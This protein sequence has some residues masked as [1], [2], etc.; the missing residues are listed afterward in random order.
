LAGISYNKFSGR[1]G[2]HQRKPDGQFVITPEMGL[3]FIASLP[4][5]KFHGVGLSPL[6]KCSGSAFRQVLTFAPERLGFCNSI[7][8]SW[9]LRQAGGLVRR[10]RE[11]RG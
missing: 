4:V 1:T 3:D 11:R 8:A 7:S 10:H 9:R 6:R 5:G 2:I